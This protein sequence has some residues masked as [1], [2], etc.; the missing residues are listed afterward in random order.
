MKMQISFLLLRIL[1]QSSMLAGKSLSCEPRQSWL[2]PVVELQDTHSSGREIFRNG[3]RR[4]WGV[5]WPSL[6]QGA[7]QVRR[8]ELVTM[9]WEGSGRVELPGGLD[10]TRPIFLPDFEDVKLTPIQKRPEEP[11]LRMGLALD[12]AKVQRCGW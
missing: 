7:G 11:G 8:L 5:A 3:D 9:G 10:F 12:Y 1:R 6:S 4:Q 2:I